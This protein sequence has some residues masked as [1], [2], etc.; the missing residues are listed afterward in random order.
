M[1]AL[2]RHLTRR[3]RLVL[4]S[5]CLILGLLA[6]TAHLHQQRDSQRLVSR[7]AAQAPPELVAELAPRI[8]RGLEGPRTRLDLARALV[9]LELDP[10]QRQQLGDADST[11]TLGL[12]EQ[13][14]REAFAHRPAAWQGPMLAGAAVYLSR[15]LARDPN[16][17]RE[18]PDWD[19]PLSRALELAPGKEEPARFLVTAYLEVWPFLAPAKR[20]TAR[21]LLRR[22][23]SNPATFLELIGPWLS[24]AENRSEA[25][26]AIPARA[27]A[28]DRLL[29]R[30]ASQGDWETYLE[31]QEPLD[32]ALEEGL[33]LRLEEARQRHR[34]GDRRGARG[35]YFEQFQHARPR[36][37][38]VPALDTVLDEVP[39]GPAPGGVLRDLGA[40]LDWSLAL[41][42][43]ERC[44]FEDREL[45]R[46]TGFAGEIAPPAKALA[47]AA[48]G[49]FDGARFIEQRFATGGIGWGRYLALKARHL[50]RQGQ[51]TEA[52]QE[53][54]RAP[55]EGALGRR[56][57]REILGARAQ[58]RSSWAADEWGW[59]SNIAR[60]ELELI[61]AGRLAV[62][63]GDVP[64]AGGVVA[65]QLDGREVGMFVAREGLVMRTEVVEPGLHLLQL[66]TLA[67]RPMRPAETRLLVR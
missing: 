23:L 11:A 17:I 46:L 13:L 62:T 49:Q 50:Q 63:L 25:F 56:L 40:W 7:L 66:S 3:W 8:H 2:E 67:G 19:R 22:T 16:L 39:P 53:L 43:I 60:L 52:Q 9:A 30:F 12:A 65:L 34:G 61:E 44:P 4:A 36:Q 21:Q 26:A 10:N 37:R 5:L 32:Q 18:A 58:P 48:A 54:A 45:A 41:C 42:A 57:H 55:I 28:W 27:F 51:I 47:R 33:G 31:A 38:W 6:L 15:S 1:K 24:V 35:K 14:A 20:D 64:P 59:G 29:E